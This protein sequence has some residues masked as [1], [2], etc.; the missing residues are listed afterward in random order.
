[1]Y[2]S[3]LKLAF[4]EVIRRDGLVVLA[5]GLGIEL[6]FAKTIQHYIYLLRTVNASIPVAITFSST[7]AATTIPTATS[8]VSRRKV[9]FVLNTGSNQPDIQQYLHS[10]GV[11]PLEMPLVITSDMPMTERRDVYSMGG[12]V[13]IT[14]RIL[15]IDLLKQN[16]FPEQVLGF[17]VY[18]AHLV[19]ET[20]IETFVI[21]VCYEA[22]HHPMTNN[23]N[24][25]TA[26]E[27]G[28]SSTEKLAESGNCFI[29]A[30]TDSVDGLFS[31]RIHVNEQQVERSSRTAD[32][33]AGRSCP[34][35]N[36]SSTSRDTTGVL[37]PASTPIV[38]RNGTITVDTLLK[39]LFVTK[40]YPFPRFH[41][42]VTDYFGDQSTLGVIE[43]PLKISVLCKAVHSAILVAIS[44]GLNELKK[45]VG[46]PISTAGNV[47]SDN[48]IDN[49]SST[50]EYTNHNDFCYSYLQKA[51][52]ET[53][54]YSNFDSSIR[55]S[56]QPRWFKL[57]IKTKSLI[58]DL[59]TLKE[60]VE[61]LLRSNISFIVS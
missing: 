18:N 28:F 52:I 48:N 21:R 3:F 47:E 58:D 20:S 45:S 30:F 33:V 24:R 60:L 14:S 49:R 11:M 34:G 15:I 54:L 29:K 25:G 22:A 56:L 32:G 53:V 41:Q 36:S 9:V 1:M 19:V 44:Q 38:A 61:S 8:G 17:L 26:S 6:L 2:P 7:K 40:V 5:K 50:T 39:N 42:P 55:S 51:T 27:V 10:I 46:L 23:S 4:E 57:S 12:L 35:P 37:T 31:N 16:I 13:F 43:C 59:H